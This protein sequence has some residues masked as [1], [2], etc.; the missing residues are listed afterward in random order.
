MNINVI[1]IRLPN[2]PHCGEETTV[3]TMGSDSP[4]IF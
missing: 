3:Y 1:F 2:A 4:L